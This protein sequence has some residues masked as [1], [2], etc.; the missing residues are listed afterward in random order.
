MLDKLVV[1]CKNDL[2]NTI[3][4]WKS[5]NPLILFFISILNL[6]VIL[7]MMFWCNQWRNWPMKQNSSSWFKIIK[8]LKTE[9]KWLKLLQTPFSLGFNDN[10]YHE[11]NISKMTDFDVFSLLE[12][13]KRKSRLHGIR[14]KGNGKWK[15]RAVKRSNTSLKDMYKVLEDYGQ[16][17]ML[18]FLSSL[19]IL[20]LRILD[21]E[22]N[23][24]YDRNH[25]LYDAAL[26]TRYYAQHALRP[27]MDSETNHKRHFIIIP[28][29]NK[30][31]KFIDYLVSLRTDLLLRRYLLISKIRNHR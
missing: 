16:H 23:K 13:R 19:P 29:I 18:S 7:L 2:A 17:S 30:G 3:V 27:F 24:F 8:R 9:L 21:T 11:G 10:I 12:T 25:Q 6:L 22:A 14:K 15:K 26:L 1:L 31:I 4:E 5:L 20:L 28:F